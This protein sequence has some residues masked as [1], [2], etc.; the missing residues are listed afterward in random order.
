ME[1]PNSNTELQTFGRYIG[2]LNNDPDHISQ[3]DIKNAIK[4]YDS[5]RADDDVRALISE[6]WKI[7]LPAVSDIPP[8]A[9]TVA[10]QSPAVQV[11]SDRERVK[12]IAIGLRKK[13]E[14]QSQ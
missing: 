8:P 10:N 14:S 2:K 11:L 5:S 13:R 9:E 12:Q 7:K 3:N 4:I 6:Q 1:I